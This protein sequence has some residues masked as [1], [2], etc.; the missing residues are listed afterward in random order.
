MIENKKE[1]SKRI[2]KLRIAKEFSQSY[3]AEKLCISQAAYS[4]LET[5][6]N[7]VSII[8]LRRLA[9]LYDETCDFL[10]T[11]NKRLIKMNLKNGFLP[12]IDAK[13]HAGFRKN[14]HKKDV[15]EDFEYYRIPGFNPTKD[16]VLIE[17]EGSSMEPTIIGGDILVCQ[18][19]HKIDRVLDGSLV[20]ILTK[21]D[22]LTRRVYRQEQKDYF[23]IKTDNP[24]QE[25]NE[26][27]KISNILQLFMVIGKVG[28]VLIPHRE[29]AFKGKLESISK[30][31][32][33]LNK[34]VYKINKKLRSGTT[35]K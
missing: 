22:L 13:A 15:M 8:H 17:V 11:G 6:Q 5:S 18:T 3:V 29:M 30:S 23:L 2:K 28:H 14:F 26:E 16:S 35:T 33:F 7:D 20:V 10:I 9:D 24:D 25:K 31:I 12:L 32:E 34:E 21:D 1:L 27:I 19:Q 4:L